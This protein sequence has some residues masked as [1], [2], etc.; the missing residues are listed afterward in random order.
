MASPVDAQ[1]ILCDAAV[2]DPAGKLHMLGAGWSVVGTPTAPHAIAVLARI[3]WDRA[4]QKISWS[5]SLLDSD[6]RAVI[7]PTPEGEQRIGQEASMEVGRPPGIT[8]GSPL[9]ASFALNVPSLPLEPGRYEWRL[10]IA[11]TELT[12]AFEVLS[13]PVG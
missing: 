3:P 6:G 7:L 12:A 10:K 11:E 13:R 1:L 9:S 8:H 4:N 5:L 2:S